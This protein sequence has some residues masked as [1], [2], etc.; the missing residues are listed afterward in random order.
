[1]RRELLDTCFGPLDSAAC[2]NRYQMV[3]LLLVNNGLVDGQQSRDRPSLF[4]IDE[5]RNDV[6]VKPGKERGVTALGSQ[7]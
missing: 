4:G 3:L 2:G 5:F 1:M 6:T 7:S